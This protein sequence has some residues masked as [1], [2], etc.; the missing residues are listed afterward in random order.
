MFPE[1]VAAGQEAIEIGDV[2][3]LAL[4]IQYLKKEA[5]AHLETS[6]TLLLLPCCQYHRQAVAEDNLSA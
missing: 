4:Y 2:G 1:I 5:D 3:M 6:S